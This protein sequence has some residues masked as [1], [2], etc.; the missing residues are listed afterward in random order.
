MTD[1][2]CMKQ[3]ACQRAA[4]EVQDGMVLGLGTGTTVYY[5]LQE[6]G[7]LVQQGLRIVGVPTSEQTAQIAGQ[8]AIPLATLEDYPALDLVVDGADEVDTLLNLVKGAGGALL[9]EKIVAVSGKRRLIVVDDGKL[10]QHL[11]E[12][13]PIPVEIVPFGYTVAQ[14]A[15]EA[16]GARVVLRRQDDGPPRLSDNGNYLMDCHFGPIADPITLQ[17]HLL[18]IPTLVDSG[19]FLGLADTVIVGDAHG[20]RLLER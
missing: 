14:R 12:R 19:L 16:L 4:A 1:R 17:K 8:L 10:V 7:R 3:R 9:R 13:Y 20:V 15:L 6:L 5:F 2:E 11:G 18:A